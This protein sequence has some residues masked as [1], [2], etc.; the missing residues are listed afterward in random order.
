MPPAEVI[1]RAIEKAVKEAATKA[2]TPELERPLDDDDLALDLAEQW[3]K[4]VAYFYNNWYVY[5]RGCWH[6]R[7]Q[8]QVKH[9][10]RQFLRD[11]RKR[12]VKVAQQRINALVQMLESDVFVADR[13]LI[14]QADACRKYINLTNGLYNL[15]TH[16]LE[17]HNP[18][19]HFTTQLAFPYD[20]QAECPNFD[21]FLRTSL[22]LPD[23]E[24]DW[25]MID[26]V[27]EALAYSMTARTDLKASFWLVGKPD[28][29]KSTM[30]GLLR[31]LMGS[32]HR[33]IDLN[34]LGVNRFLLSEIVGKRVVTFTEASVGSFLPDAL[35]KAIVGGADEIYADVKNRPG[36]TFVPEA[37]FWWAMN[38]APRT[39]DRSGAVMNRLRVIVFN[40]SIPQDKRDPALLPKME[41]ELSGIFNDLVSAYRRLCRAG[42][43]TRPAQSEAWREQYRMEND[44]EAV[45]IRER[46]E[47]APGHWVF[48]EPLYKD[49]K[50]WCEEFGYKPR[51]ITQ[52]ARE[53]RRL[54]FQDMGYQGRTRWHGLMLKPHV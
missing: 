22:V 19:L 18:D 11:Y 49:Y 35:Y 37:K 36:I 44:T 47:V 24:T 2:N 39:T 31:A 33:T 25:R 1:E 30:I 4:Q 43:F 9:N 48:G 40:H 34:Q 10:I 46:C 42:D 14:A 6:P 45:Y 23:G 41:R 53:W 51:N 12:G 28:S 20:E 52:A 8:Q 29:G 13:D 26:L 54:G 7:A 15:E 27:K 32:L 16:E 38:D 21:R 3:R 5:E 50:N 17:P